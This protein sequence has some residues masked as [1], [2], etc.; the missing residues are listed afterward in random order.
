MIY[1]KMP[2]TYAG[3]TF[4]DAVAI[5][6]GSCDV[7]QD[8]MPDGENHVRTHKTYINVNHYV[9][10]TAYLN[11]EQPIKKY[12]SYSETIRNINITDVST[13]EI[14]CMEILDNYDPYFESGILIDTENP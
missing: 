6:V 14:R 3:M 9:S 12:S 13:F 11:N 7:I 10:Y 8:T 2:I 4:T 5:Y 1:I